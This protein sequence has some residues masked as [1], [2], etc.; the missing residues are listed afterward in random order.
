M[1]K[2]KVVLAVILVLLIGMQSAA[3]ACTIVLVGKEATTDGSTI[4]THNDD[5]TSA[6][7]RL[8]IIPSMEG[9]EGLKRDLVIDSHNYGDFGDYPN[10]K[11]YGN[12]YAVTEIDQTEDTYAYLHSRYSFINE[13]GVAMGESTFSLDKTDYVEQVKALIYAGDYMIDCWNAQDI[14]LERAATAREAVEV[15][16]ELIDT[17]GWR[18][19]GETINIC[20]GN[21]AWV[22]EAYGGYLWCAVRIPDDAF[23]V[24]ANRARICEVDFEDTENYLYSANLKSFAIENGL[25]SEDSETPFSPAEIYAPCTNTYCTRREWRALDLVAPS[26]EL[27]PNAL[28]F[29][30]YVIPEEKLSVQDVFEIKGDYYQGTEYDVSL[31]T[32][33]GDYG[34]PIN[35]NNTERPINMFRTCYVM[36]ANVKA[37]LPDEAKCLV[38]YGYGAPDSTF[39]VP[40]WASQT[41]L[42]ELFSTGSRYDDFNR[43]SGWWISSYVQQ[44]ATINYD[45]AIE[46]IHER[47]QAFMDEQYETVAQ[48][49]EEAAALI[50]EGK[51]DEAVAML[52][53]YACTN[54]ET[55]FAEWLKLGDELQGDLMWGY[56]SMKNPGY[57]DWWKGVLSSGAATMKPVVEEEAATN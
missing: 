10:T 4:T 16:G 5:S 24:A 57:S 21:E 44:T 54:A 53:E 31:T 47:R 46:V 9:G 13:K 8:W 35:P 34:N 28:R 22:F 45:Y 38:W 36:I 48:K 23:F 25:W 19:A 7:F 33:A 51:N 20:D 43:E 1:K 6:D 55:H 37:D 56:V 50:A 29:P 39:L 2:I 41:E 42:P 26:L 49:Q 30:L 3:M 27:D 32:M 12:G 17:F 14:A 11:D 40:L 18:D 15:M 52:T